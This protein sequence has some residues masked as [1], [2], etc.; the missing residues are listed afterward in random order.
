MIIII[1]NGKEIGRSCK[2]YEE[3]EKIQYNQKLVEVFITEKLYI[4]I[5]LTVNMDANKLER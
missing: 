1:R 3:I 5:N 4:K 2:K